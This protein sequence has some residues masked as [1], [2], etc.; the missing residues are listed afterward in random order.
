MI[1]LSYAKQD[2][3]VARKLYIDLNDNEISVW[4]DE[5]FLKPGQRWR[6]AI[7]TAIKKSKYFIALLSLNSISKK[8]YVQKELKIAFDILDEHPSSKI[9]I[10]PIRIDD[11][12]PEDERIKSLH[13]LNLNQNWNDGINK[14]VSIIKDIS[15]EKNEIELDIQQR[16]LISQKHTE[17][18]IQAESKENISQVVNGNHNIFSVKGDVTVTIAK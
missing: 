5:V 18:A 7:N 6:E 14:I 8:G 10:I 4:F 3:D 17:K 15:D 2:I 12:E 11:C 16:E 13:W 9:F 1:F